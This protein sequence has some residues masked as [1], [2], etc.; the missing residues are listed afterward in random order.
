MRNATGFSDILA[1][2]S[3]KLVEIA[4]ELSKSPGTVDYFWHTAWPDGQ[5]RYDST[6]LAHE[7]LVRRFDQKESQ[8]SLK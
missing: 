6:K 5:N 3:G 4:R 7:R 2:L 8:I 1:D